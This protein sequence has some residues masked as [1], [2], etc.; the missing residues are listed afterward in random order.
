[1]SKPHKVEEPAAAYIAPPV[2]PQQA[3]VSASP[4]VRMLDEASA[5]KIADEIFPRRKKLLHKL[6]Q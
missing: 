5:K 3:A 1:M 2:P 4:K 6:A